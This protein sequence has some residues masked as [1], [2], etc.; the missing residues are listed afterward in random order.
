MGIMKAQEDETEQET[1][2]RWGSRTRRCTRIG[3][4]CQRSSW[5]RGC[6][7][8]TKHW[9]M[10]RRPGISTRFGRNHRFGRR[11]RFRHR[12]WS[13]GLPNPRRFGWN[14]ESCLS[15]PRRRVTT[16]TSHS[17]QS[18]NSMG[19]PKAVDTTGYKNMSCALFACQ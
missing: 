10:P 9:T 16:T 4:Q 3:N 1:K 7:W 5:D 17:E 14:W 15:T 2:C 19:G 6:R 18:Q 13:G 12:W 11:H 8:G